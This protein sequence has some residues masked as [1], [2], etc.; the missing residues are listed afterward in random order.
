MGIIF[1]GTILN[2]FILTQPDGKIIGEFNKKSNLQN[3]TVLSLKE[4]RDQ[5]LWIGMDK[6]IDLVSL[7]ASL[8]YFTDE[9]GQIG[10]VYTSIEQGNLLYIG[11]NQGLFACHALRAF[12]GELAILAKTTAVFARQVEVGRWCV[13]LPAA[14]IGRGATGKAVF[15]RFS[16]FLANDFQGGLRVIDCLHQP[17]VC[18]LDA[19]AID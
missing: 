8:H 10:T 1:F 2:G 11:T 19:G 12:A 3:N 18:G 13:G 14:A 6:G 17:A 7:D 16:E 4:D 9:S 5:N 15:G